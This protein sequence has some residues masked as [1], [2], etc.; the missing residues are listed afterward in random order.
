MSFCVAPTT[1]SEAA[2]DAY[3]A[4]KMSG[5]RLSIPLEISALGDDLRLR[6]S[7]KVTQGIEFNRYQVSFKLTKVVI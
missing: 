7:L 6:R 5:V 3:E 1:D 2:V 4:A